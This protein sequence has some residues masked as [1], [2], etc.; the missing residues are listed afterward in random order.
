VVEQ[1]LL[2]DQIQ[3]FQPLHLQVEVE[4]VHQLQLEEMVDLEVAVEE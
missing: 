3:Y 1:H 4:V 2:L